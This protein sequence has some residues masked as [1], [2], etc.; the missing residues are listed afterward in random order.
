VT[1]SIFCLPLEYVSRRFAAHIR[2]MPGPAVLG[3]T[4]QDFVERVCLSPAWQ[5][6]HTSEFEPVQRGIDDGVVEGCGSSSPPAPDEDLPLSFTA[7]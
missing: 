1:S 6:C 5:W 2:P 3:S 7:P 4:R